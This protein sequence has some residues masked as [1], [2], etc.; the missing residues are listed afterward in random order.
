[1]N[2]SPKFRW[3]PCVSGRHANLVNKKIQT[4]PY[5]Q[6]RVNIFGNTEAFFIVILV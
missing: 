4:H 3:T 5:F 2:G 6:S 1:M